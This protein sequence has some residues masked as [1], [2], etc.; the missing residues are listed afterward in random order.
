MSLANNSSTK[1]KDLAV[2]GF[3]AADNILSKWG[4]T[5]KQA[6]NILKLSKSS[7]HKFKATPESTKLSDDQLE[8][9]SYILNM[10]QALRIVFSNPQNVTGF[11]TMKNNNEYFAGRTPLEVIESGKF[12][13]LY[14]VFKRVDALRGGLWG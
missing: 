8:R 5:A 1:T 2:P 3:K 4:C 9:V 7:Y 11:M 12:A 10:H 14:E 13:D 6:Q